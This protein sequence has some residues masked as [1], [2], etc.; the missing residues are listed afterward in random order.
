MPGLELITYPDKRLK[1][2]SKPFGPFN[3]QSRQ[4]LLELKI[5]MMETMYDKGG[6]GL[7][8]IQI[9]IPYRI[10]LVDTGF[11]FM[12][13]G[14]FMVNPEILTTSK[15]TASINEGCLSL[16]GY[17]KK[18]ERAETCSVSFRDHTGKANKISATGLL[19]IVIQHEMDHLNG[20]TLKDK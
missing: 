7:A 15:K 16:P 13:K 8:A 20:I 3:E 10:L 1:Q 19:S 17:K 14:I 4:W 6:I 11:P 5:G 12:K 18:V 9:G 2:V